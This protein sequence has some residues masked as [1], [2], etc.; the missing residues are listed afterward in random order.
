MTQKELAALLGITQAAVSKLARKGMP[1]DTVERATRW[2][3]RHLQTGRMKGV[4]RDSAPAAPPG[5]DAQPAEPKAPEDLDLFDDEDEDEK[6]LRQFRESRDRREHYAA[7]MAQLNYER[8]AGKL[9][10]AS[11]VVGFVASAATELRTTLEALPQQVAPILAGKDEGV[12][13]AHLAAE[14]EH[15]L[16][17]LSFRFASLAQEGR[18]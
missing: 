4:R 3:R 13:A 5:Q 12:I 10:L 6:H 8:E 17:N 11:E 14:I 18:L 9:L 7:Q 16:E 15:V 2:R 1:T